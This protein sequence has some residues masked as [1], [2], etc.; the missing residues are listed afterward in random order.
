[1]LV[2][3]YLESWSRTHQQR[4]HAEALQMYGER[5][6]VRH[7]WNIQDYALGRVARCTACSAGTKLNEQQRVRVLGA[8]AGT[9]TLTFDGQETSALQWNASAPEV[10]AALEAL[11]VNA[12][13]DVNVTGEDIGNLG[14]VVE[15]KGQW[16]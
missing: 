12:P 9:F 5:V 7:R 16:S 6:I 13:G 2:V 3:K 15:F 4:F 8:T 10:Q 14:L 11:E 1:M